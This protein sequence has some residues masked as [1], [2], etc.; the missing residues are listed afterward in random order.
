MG[1]EYLCL[2]GILRP[3]SGSSSSL[4]VY[5]EDVEEREGLLFA[6]RFRD[7]QAYEKGEKLIRTTTGIFL[8]YCLTKEISRRGA[9]YAERTSLL[10]I[11]VVLPRFIE[12]ND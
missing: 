6:K 2:L 12:R 1:G 9:H 7:I 3:S 4:G 11:D 5:V 10:L 8:L